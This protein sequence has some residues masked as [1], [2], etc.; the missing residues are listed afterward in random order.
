MICYQQKGFNDRVASIMDIT[1]GSKNHLLSEILSEMLTHAHTI[2]LFFF[3]FFFQA[4]DGI[5]DV[6]VT[7]VQTCAL[8]ISGKK[9]ADKQVRLQ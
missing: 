9:N 2:V 1:T 3:I 4:K 7:G 6:A 5:R 8:P